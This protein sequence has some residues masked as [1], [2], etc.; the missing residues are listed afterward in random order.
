MYDWLS[1]ALHESAVVATAS[2]R[3]ARELSSEY[4]AQQLAQ[5]CPAWRSPAVHAWQ[6]WLSRLLA[7][8]D[9]QAGLPTR[10]NA[11]HSRIL[12]ERCLRREIAD[13][14]MNM[15][16]LVRQARETWA[17]M[18]DFVV[19]LEECRD[20]AQGRDQRLF[21]SAAASYQS[22]LERERWVDDAGIADLVAEL[23]K[24]QGV[25]LPEKLTLAGFD[26]VVPRVSM[27]L[28]ELRANGV[29]VAHAGRRE[30][31][32]NA[33]LHV[34]DNRDDELRSAGAWVRQ[35][36]LENADQR[37]AIVVTNLE[38]EADRCSRLVREGLAPGWQYAGPR[39]AGAVNVS[40]GQPLSAYPAC[41]IALLLLRWL[42]GE[43]AGREVSLVLR[44]PFLEAGEI[45]GRTRLELRLRRMPDRRWTPAMLLSEFGEAADRDGCGEWLEALNRLAALRESL[46]GRSSPAR[47]AAIADEALACFGWPG[48]E[49]SSSPEFQLINRW[50]E[51]L[52]ELAKLDLVSPKLS[53]AE[54]VS[55]LNLM[56]TETVFQPEAEDTLVQV[57]GPLEAAGM[58]FDRIWV[59]G[60]GSAEWPPPG[61]PLALLSRDLQRRYRMP[62]ADPADTLEYAAGVLSGLLSCAPVPVCSYSRTHGDTE[63][64][65]TG[66]LAGLVAADTSRPQDPGWHAA[67]LVASGSAVLVAAD[68]TPSMR[69]GEKLAGGAA[70]L[71]RQLEEP[72]S[73]FV[74]GRL[75]VNL[76]QSITVGLSPSVRGSLIHGAL[77]QL[78]RE[79]PAQSA[80][81]NW[82]EA[83]LERRVGDAVERAFRKV[84]RNADAVLLALLELETSRTASLLRAVVDLDRG[85]EP[86]A[87]AAV[88][89]PLSVAIEEVSL[90]LQA[91]RIDR[92]DSGE[93][94]IL[95]YKT[96]AARQFLGSDKK[97]RDIQLVVYA[98]AFGGEVSDLGL[99]NV[100]SRNVDID[101]AGRTLT[102]GIDWAA[103]LPDWCSIAARAA[104]E[105][106]QGDIRLSNLHSRQSERP[107]SL[108]SRSRELR[109]DA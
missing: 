81:R 101:G 98:F 20:S 47:W 48:E 79:L 60:L 85:R 21:A 51:L 49:P 19:T 22:I 59:S 6:D 32:A 44:S 65:A 62:D 57:I 13:P 64:T 61:R 90:S 5:G 75:G 58:Q 77:Q 3:L 15:S 54:A 1:D 73:A 71:Q 42:H 46:Q 72:F 28:D 10:I 7:E 25:E 104:R 55:R 88:E 96:G 38:R 74:S 106:R 45:S 109:D 76:L 105:L 40:Y 107:L 11:H 53:I 39:H 89:Q 16:L 94:V 37:I 8:A 102:P 56:A 2:R 84:L 36:L 70:V 67:A 17:R 41:A 87:V 23:V 108:L 82:D 26:R 9:D 69:P 63:Q 100:D 29:T 27:L 43:L 83:E 30:A 18:Q 14:M 78:Y 66:L 93:H 103:V 91:D 35:Q 12:W 50:R 99:V 68:P 4:G 97:P 92:L 31:T 86:F 24:N 95:D 52:N 80:I 34:F 33:D